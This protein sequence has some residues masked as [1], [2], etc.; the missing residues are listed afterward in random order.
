M[1]KPL[2]WLEFTTVFLVSRMPMLIDLFPLT[3][4]HGTLYI[5]M[6]GFHTECLIRPQ[7]PL[8]RIWLR[9]WQVFS[10][11][12][13]IT[14]SSLQRRLTRVQR[15]PVSLMTFYYTRCSS[16]WSCTHRLLLIGRGRFR[17][18]IVA[19]F[20][21]SLSFRHTGVNLVRRSTKRRCWSNSVYSLHGMWHH[22][23]VWPS[24]LHDDLQV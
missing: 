6:Y 18:Q 16:L 19:G 20:A 5:I 13:T 17:Q 24:F 12:W 11:Q 1:L 21:W 3:H 22:C 7:D 15:S 4:I 8:L 23:L 10:L 2:V 14:K 9:C